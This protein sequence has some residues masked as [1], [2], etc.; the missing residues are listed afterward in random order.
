VSQNDLSSK[1][2]VRTQWRRH[3]Q[4]SYWLLHCTYITGVVSSQWANN[5][6]RLY[7]CSQLSHHSD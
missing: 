2:A 7:K 1:V 4:T 3:I 6:S 5:L